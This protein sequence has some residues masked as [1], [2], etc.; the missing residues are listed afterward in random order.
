MRSFIM[1]PLGD[2]N[3]N[4][5]IPGSAIMKETKPKTK[6]LQTWYFGAN[7]TGRSLNKDTIFFNVLFTNIFLNI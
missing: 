5:V 6:K 4:R 1:Q 3:V 7:K 2:S